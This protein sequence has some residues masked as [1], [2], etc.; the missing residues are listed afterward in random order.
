MTRRFPADPNGR[1]GRSSGG[2]PVPKFIDGPLAGREVDSR[3]HVHCELA[4]GPG[5]RVDFSWGYV[6][7]RDLHE[8]ERRPGGD[9]VFSATVRG[10]TVY[11]VRNA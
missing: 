3:A 7:S 9:Y 8:Y 2:W 4:D 10:G 6:V 5:E 11:T 1:R